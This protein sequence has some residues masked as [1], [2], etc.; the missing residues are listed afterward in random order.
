MYR[1]VSSTCPLVVHVH[2][3]SSPLYADDL[4]GLAPALL[5][6]PTQ[7]AVAD[8]GRRYA[9]RLRAA[10]TSVRLTEYPGAKHG[11]SPCR[12]WSREPRPRGW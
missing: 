10:G 2:G 8:H 11:S 12:A 6:V 7:D 3:G 1:P 9:E 4:R 5:V